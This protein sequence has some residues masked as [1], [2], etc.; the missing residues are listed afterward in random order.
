VNDKVHALD[1]SKKP[2]FYYGYVVV[3]AGFFIML[4]LWGTIYSYG[5]FFKPMAGE[6]G[7]TRAMTSGAYSLYMILHGGLYLVTGRLTDRFGPRKVMTVCALFFGAGFILMSQVNAIWQLYLFYGVLIGIGASGGSVPV[8]STVA[9]WFVRRR[10]IMTALTATGVG[11]GTIIVPLIARRLISSYDWHFSYL[12]V[13]IVALVVLVLASQF[14]RRDPA[15]MGH[16]PYGGGEIEQP[17]L[18]LQVEGFSFWEAIRTQPFWL[19][20]L[21]MFVFGS[22]AQASIVHIVP[23]ATDLGISPTVAAG[24]IAIFGGASIGGRVG[25]GGAA[26]RVG[27]K[28]VLFIGY[29]LFLIAFLLIIPARELWALYLF[30]VIFG[31]AYGGGEVLMSPVVAELFGL[32]ALGAIL[33]ATIFAATLGGTVAPLLAGYIFDVT[34]SYQLAFIVFAVLSIV[35]LVLVLLLKPTKKARW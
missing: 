6:F 35:A 15:Q 24:I 12:I 31:I 3:I 10:G 17:D 16:L 34:L 30:A 7:W 23:H 9:R 18:I 26:D 19:F 21:I 28:K 20:C 29:V 27:K 25:M 14:L 33:G 8:F 32:K 5:V 11:V 2:R 13:G 22:V 4:V 1:N